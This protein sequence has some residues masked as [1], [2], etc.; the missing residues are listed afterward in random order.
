MRRWFGPVWTMPIVLAVL[1]IAGLVGA[2]LED[3]WWD[4]VAALALAAPVAVGAWY[5]W[6]RPA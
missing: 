3:G 2:L 1:T 6:R 5:S 4:W